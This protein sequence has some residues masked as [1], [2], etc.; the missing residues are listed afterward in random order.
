MRLRH[1]E[2]AVVKELLQSKE[3]LLHLRLGV[4]VIPEHLV[5]VRRVF[6]QKPRR[7][8][9]DRQGIGI[10]LLARL[11]VLDVMR[12]NL[13]PVERM[14][15]LGQG[16]QL[17]RDHIRLGQATL[18]DGLLHQLRVSLANLLPP[19]LHPCWIGGGP[20]AVLTLG[21]PPQR[22]AVALVQALA[23]GR[24]RE[25]LLQELRQGCQPPQNVTPL[26]VLIGEVVDQVANLMGQ[27][28]GGGDRIE[29]DRAIQMDFNPA[30]PVPEKSS[31]TTAQLPQLGQLTQQLLGQRHQLRQH[32]WVDMIQTAQLHLHNLRR[33]ALLDRGSREGDL[34]ANRPVFH[35]QAS[36]SAL[37][38][39]PRVALR[40]AQGCTPAGWGCAAGND[41]GQ[42][43]RLD[44]CVQYIGLFRRERPLEI[45][46]AGGGSRLLRLPADRGH[47]LVDRRGEVQLGERPHMAGGGRVHERHMTFTVHDVLAHR[48][49]IL[50]HIRPDR[51]G[52]LRPQK[53]IY[54]R[55][56]RLDNLAIPLARRIHE[57]RLAVIDCHRAKKK[58]FKERILHQ[59]AGCLHVLGARLGI[60]GWMIM[61]HVKPVRAV[62]LE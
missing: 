10:Q 16:D 37:P 23:A 19:A 48:S 62:G 60:A 12:R 49:H 25:S 3:R 9:H 17:T 42:H 59:S 32:Y 6:L 39:E 40:Q 7:I 54:L 27:H 46:E 55:P 36:L 51:P 52:N 11:P 29:E 41:I 14:P 31:C 20:W 35:H 58:R 38:P 13:L 21:L 8:K 22:G 26:Q 56:C 4:D 30:R 2:L 34:R 43:A 50:H 45:G 33:F 47:Q 53:W 18:L 1:A 24:D 15:E 61:H 44:E 57:R 28:L 5:E